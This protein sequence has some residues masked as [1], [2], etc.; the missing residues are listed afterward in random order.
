[1]VMCSKWSNHFVVGRLCNVPAATGNQAQTMALRQC[2][3]SRDQF[4]QCHPLGV[5]SCG[6]RY[7]TRLFV[8]AKARNET[9]SKTSGLLV[10]LGAWQKTC[11]ALRKT[12]IAAKHFETQGASFQHFAVKTF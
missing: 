5:D 2:D 12:R 7:L 10:V 6:T 8:S 3:R 4:S 1:M 9:L 11:P